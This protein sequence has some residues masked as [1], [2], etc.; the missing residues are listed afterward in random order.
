MHDF[1][2]TARSA[3]ASRIIDLHGR[4]ENNQQCGDINAQESSKC[5]S[6][7]ENTELKGMDMCYHLRS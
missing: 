5:R 4:E 1:E 3:P 7:T 2:D 6:S